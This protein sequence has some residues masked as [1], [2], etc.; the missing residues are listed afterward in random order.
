MNIKIERIL[1]KRCNNKNCFLFYRKLDY[2]DSER[3]STTIKLK[4]YR[5]N[6]EF[7]LK[8]KDRNQTISINNLSKLRIKRIN[9]KLN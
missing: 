6:I 4:F 5:S 1:Q 3:E 2:Y 9:E 7:S 8:K